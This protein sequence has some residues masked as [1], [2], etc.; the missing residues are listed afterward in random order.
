MSP[1]AAATAAPLA[2]TVLGDQLRR[3]LH[4]A[5]TWTQQQAHSQWISASARQGEPQI[6]H[7][8]LHIIHMF[9]VI[10]G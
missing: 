9:T 1:T 10:L 7:V 3:V 6:I 2:S 4:A 5:P 8:M